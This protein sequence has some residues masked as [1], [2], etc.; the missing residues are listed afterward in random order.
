MEKEDNNVI[1]R[2]QVEEALYLIL[3]NTASADVQGQAEV[4]R[5]LLQ[6]IDDRES[7]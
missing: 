5:L 6:M 1:T 7:E 2:E 4:A 3:R